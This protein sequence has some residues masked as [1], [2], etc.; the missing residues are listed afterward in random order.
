M[1][2]YSAGALNPDK[3]IIM[4]WIKEWFRKIWQR[5]NF[6]DEER[7]VDNRGNSTYRGL[8]ARN[9]MEYLGIS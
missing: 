4:E 3:G 1:L 5:N 6:E 7:W 8:G 9:S 2:G